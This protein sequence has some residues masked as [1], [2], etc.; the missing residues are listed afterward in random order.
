MSVAGPEV[1]EDGT[2]PSRTNLGRGKV[3]PGVSCGHLFVLAR[4]PE[5]SNRCLNDGTEPKGEIFTKCLSGMKTSRP[6][7]VQVEGSGL[8]RALGPDPLGRV[9]TT[10]TGRGGVRQ[11]V[12]GGGAGDGR[13][14]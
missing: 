12:R 11:D 10:D 5:E 6:P 8:R 3:A 13:D 7:Q 14:E 1:L 4:D 9:T 2:R